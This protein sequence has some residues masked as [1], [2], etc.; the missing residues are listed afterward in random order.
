MAKKRKPIAMDANEFVKGVREAVSPG[1][2]LDT[3]TQRRPE[4]EPAP[5]PEE[6]ELGELHQE[7]TRFYRRLDTR[8]TWCGWHM[9]LENVRAGQRVACPKP[10]CHGS[11]TVGERPARFET[12]VDRLPEN[13]KLPPELAAALQTDRPALA[14]WLNRSLP[15]EEASAIGH[16]FGVLLEHNR[17]LGRRVQELEHHLEL[18]ARDLLTQVS[19]ARG[20]EAALSRIHRYTRLPVNPDH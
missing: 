16:A 10:T 9:H 8:C 3:D 17:R 19:V 11:V 14:G 1:T 20:L 15:A 6:E 2:A 18:L 7:R 12:D 13:V 4:P 5:D